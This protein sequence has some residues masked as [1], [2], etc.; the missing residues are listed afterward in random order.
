MSLTNNKQH[1]IVNGLHGSDSGTESEHRSSSAVGLSP[2]TSV[3]HAF[4]L[5]K[6][7]QRVTSMAEIVLNP[8]G[9]TLRHFGV[10]CSVEAEPGQSQRVLGERLRIDRTTVVALTDDL[11][12]AG[13]LERRR[14]ADRRAFSLHLTEAG[15]KHLGELKNVVDEV[16]SEFLEPL[17]FA[18]QA[19]LRDLLLKLTVSPTACCPCQTIGAGNLQARC[20]CSQERKNHGHGI[21]QPDTQ[22]RALPGETS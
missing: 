17:S 13:L 2:A 12:K 22:E 11:E 18:E 9:L 1:P 10:L 7:T 8:H 4:L 6:A 16:H 14:G 19:M 20:A 15:D 3:W 21:G 5:R